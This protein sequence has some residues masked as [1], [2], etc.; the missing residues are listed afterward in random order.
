MIN[1]NFT[2]N[3]DINKRMKNIKKIIKVF[4]SIGHLRAISLLQNLIGNIYM[5]MQNFH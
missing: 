4:E 2:L 5:A 1:P 3:P